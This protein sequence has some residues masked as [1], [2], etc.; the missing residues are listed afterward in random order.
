MIERLRVR[1]PAEAAVEF[2]SPELTLCADSYSVPQW[3]VKDL[4]QCAKSEDGRLHLN[5]HT[6]CTHRSRSGLTMPRSRHSVGI[7]QETSSHATRQGTLDGSRLQLAELP[8]S[9]LV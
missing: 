2:S 5:T 9:I 3:H 6:P 8:W 1:I 7:Y 4:G